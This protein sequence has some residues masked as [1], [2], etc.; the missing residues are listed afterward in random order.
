MSFALPRL[1]AIIDAAQ[2]GNRSTAAVS[3]ALLAAGVKLIQYRD[4]QA[5]SRV[6]Y[7]NS[8]ELAARARQANA[9]LIVNDRADV[10]RVVQAD[11]VHVG[12]DDLSVEL[13]RRVLGAGKR[14]G[15]STHHPDQVRDAERSSADYIAFGPIFETQSKQQP[16]PVVGLEGL[17]DARRLTRKPLVAIGGITLENAR[18]VMEAGADS[19]A[20]ISDLL[21]PDDIESRARDFLKLLGGL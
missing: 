17:R 21:T 9:V 4:K 10:A 20:V 13:V 7:E 16:D 2:T 5:S 3:D 6:L 15:C 18:A 14:I 8:F 12:Q 19:V 1:Y 11:G